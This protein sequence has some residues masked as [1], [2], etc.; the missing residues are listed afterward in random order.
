MA[1]QTAKTRN[2]ERR[3]GKAWGKSH[4]PTIKTL[5]PEQQER[6]AQKDAERARKRSPRREPGYNYTMPS[7]TWEW[8]GETMRGQ[9]TNTR[10]FKMVERCMADERGK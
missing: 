10:R 2:P 9:H 3:S 1:K 6:K 4:T 5:T 8:A 7:F